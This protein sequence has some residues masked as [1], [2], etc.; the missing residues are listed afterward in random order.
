MLVDT[1]LLLRRDNGLEKAGRGFVKGALTLPS[2]FHRFSLYNTRISITCLTTGPTY[3]PTYLLTYLPTYL[4]THLPRPT[5]TYQ[6]LYTKT[7][8]DLPRPT[9]TYQDLPSYPHC[10]LRIIALRPNR[11]RDHRYKGPILYVDLGMVLTTISSLQWHVSF[12]KH[13]LLHECVLPFV[14]SSPSMS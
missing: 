8:Q 9:K 3:L 11:T 2:F 10:T 12:F 7:Y 13:V 14:R 5:K 4:P 1:T 6:D